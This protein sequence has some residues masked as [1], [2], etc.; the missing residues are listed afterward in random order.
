MKRHKEVLSQVINLFI[1][2]KFFLIQ[3]YWLMPGA[4]SWLSNNLK[5]EFSCQSK[6][7]IRCRKEWVLYCYEH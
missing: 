7:F 6:I 5:I 1:Y 3:T 2:K 4:V